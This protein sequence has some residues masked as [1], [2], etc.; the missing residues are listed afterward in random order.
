VTTRI[1]ALVAAFAVLGGALT[2]CASGPSQVNAA[3]II[4]DRVISIDD[5][6]HRLDQSLNNE[7]ATKNL[8]RNHKLDLVSRGIVNQLVRHELLAESA[9]RESLSISEKD[10][11]D[12]V[13]AAAPPE[14]P[15]QRAVDA[16]FDQRDVIRDRLLALALGTKYLD[17]VRITFDGAQLPAA[18]T[19]QKAID[20]AKKAAAQPNNALNL[21]AEA[22]GPESQPIKSYPMDSVR[23]YAFATGQ[24]QLNVA[25]LFA[26]P[27]NSTFAFPLG[28]GQEGGGGNGWLVGIV[29]ER[30][31]D[32]TLPEEEAAVAAQVKPEWSE[33]VGTYLAGQLMG[34]L[35]VRISP[36]YGVWD[37][38]AVGVAPSEAELS[39]AV[40]PVAAAKS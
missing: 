34:E 38:L 9:R 5:V 7:Q 23:G 40:V 24:N 33:L 21:F 35:G 28:G 15:V 4:G 20:L 29:K 1:P 18:E 37:P 13:A 8:A 17:K 6:Q 14:D 30:K 22:G 19:K 36:R 12:A 32:A 10:V 31:L 39:G 3:V 11:N 25:P 16:A 27:A 2:A 26:V